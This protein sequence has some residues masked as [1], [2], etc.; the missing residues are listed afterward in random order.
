MSARAQ[1]RSPADRQGRIM[2]QA[3]RGAGAAG[4]RDEQRAVTLTRRWSA[5]VLCVGTLALLAYYTLLALVAWA[6]AGLGEALG[7]V[8]RAGSVTVADVLVVAALP[9]TV[10]WGVGLAAATLLGRHELRPVVGGLLSGL[11]G[12]AAGAAV[13]HGQGLL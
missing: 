11:L 12:V 5:A 10:G 6:L 7:L 13:L 8:D 4:A 3:R 2:T 1:A 9:G